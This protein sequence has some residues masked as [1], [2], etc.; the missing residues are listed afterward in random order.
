MPHRLE[1]TL[2]PELTDAEGEAIRRKAEFQLKTFR[3]WGK[4]RQD[5]LA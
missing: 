3:K 5:K 2:K 1:I 4:Y